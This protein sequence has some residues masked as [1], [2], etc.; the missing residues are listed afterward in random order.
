MT[1][2]QIAKETRKVV[3]AELC[4]KIYAKKLENNGRVP[5]GYVAKVI[6]E[7]CDVAPWLTRDIL[8]CQLE[9]IEASP[10]I[11]LQQLILRASLVLYLQFLKPPLKMAIAYIYLVSS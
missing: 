8:H 6:K 11:P 4:K 1:L 2:T 7:N 9:E 5:Y 10:P 3:V